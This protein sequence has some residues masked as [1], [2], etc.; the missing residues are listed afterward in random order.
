MIARQGCPFGWAFRK[1][2]IDKVFDRL[3]HKGRAPLE[4]SGIFQSSRELLASWHHAIDHA[5]VKG[6]LRI[7]VLPQQHKFHR[8]FMR[9]PCGATGY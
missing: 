9:H 2:L 4:N 7:N 5:H 1:R 3:H 8:N 6:T